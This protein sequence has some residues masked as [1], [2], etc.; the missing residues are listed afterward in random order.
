MLSLNLTALLL[1][2]PQESGVLRMLSLPTEIAG[3]RNYYLTALSV[4][5]VDASAPGE[6]SVRPHA[7][8]QALWA[9]EAGNKMTMMLC[10]QRCLPAPQK[11]MEAV[12]KQWKERNHAIGC[13]QQALVAE[14]AWHH[15]EH[16]AI[17]PVDS[18]HDAI[19][20]VGS[21]HDSPAAH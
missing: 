13:D 14:Y 5:A 16:D 15:R 3:G 17:E 8:G 2:V 20:P 6:D 4:L 21:E 10:W 7:V 11:T 12:E 1:N 18:E 19:V 9:L